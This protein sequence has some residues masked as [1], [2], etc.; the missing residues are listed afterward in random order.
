M[1]K[2][3]NVMMYFMVLIM[4]IGLSACAGQQ[5]K[6]I[7]W[8]DDCC[9]VTAT[10]V[11]KTKVIILEDIMFDWDKDVIR[12]DQQGKLDRITETM[13]EHPE[14]NILLDGH[15]SIEGATDYNFDLS[16]RRANAVKDVLVSKGVEKNRII[17]TQGKGETDIFGLELSPNRRVQVSSE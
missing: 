1:K 4:A 5:N 6:E 2:M 15:A 9:K 3:K 14:V 13:I 16:N 12:D 8:A 11:T 10:C 7:V 17:N